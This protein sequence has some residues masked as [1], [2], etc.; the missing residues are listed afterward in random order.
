[1]FT[2]S[3]YAFD[4]LGSGL[5]VGESGFQLA[6]QTVNRTEQKR[7]SINDYKRK[8]QELVATTLL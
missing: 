5:I 8:L 2:L 1:L 7:V 4:P 3:K 6:G